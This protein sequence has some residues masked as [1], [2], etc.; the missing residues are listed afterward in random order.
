MKNQIFLTSKAFAALF[1]LIGVLSCDSA[2]SQKKV[3]SFKSKRT[4]EET[5]KARNFANDE[6]EIFRLINQVRRKNNLSQLVWDDELAEMA[7]DYSERMARENFFSHF[8]PDGG[9]AAKRAK[10][11]KLKNWSKIGEN[12]FSVERFPR[13]AAFAVK[14]WMKSPTHER[15]ILDTDWT[16]TGIGIT[17]AENGDIYVTQ[18]FIRR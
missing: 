16:T 4:A 3:N 7:R 14:G 18:L 8:D 11:A 1:F 12:L 15:N 10:K 9:N 2:F 6:D 17:E 13:F 5:N